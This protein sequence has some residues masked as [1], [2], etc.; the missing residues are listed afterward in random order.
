[1]KRIL[2][3]LACFILMGP[4]A[5][6]SGSKGSGPSLLGGSEV[7]NPD[8]EQGGSEVGNPDP[9][10]GGAEAGNPVEYRVVKGYFNSK[11]DLDTSKVCDYDRVVFVNE[12]L[13]HTLRSVTD[14][15][16][17]E[18]SIAVNQGWAVVPLAPNEQF[19]VS[20]LGE[21]EIYKV[22]GPGESTE[23]KPVPIDLGLIQ[24]NPVTQKADPEYPIEAVDL[25]VGVASPDQDGDGNPDAL[26]NEMLAVYHPGD[27]NNRSR[28]DIEFCPLSHKGVK[29]ELR[30]WKMIASS[31]P[32]GAAGR[33]V[34]VNGIELVIHSM[35]VG[36]MAAVIPMKQEVFKGTIE[37]GFI[38]VNGLSFIGETSYT[39]EC[40]GWTSHEEAVAPNLNLDVTC[41]YTPQGGPDTDGGMCYYWDFLPEAP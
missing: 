14:E 38:R 29:L 6:P 15:C 2:L 3:I 30:K 27:I 1:M 22:I 32:R 34:P 16:R 36:S 12:K 11:E 31:N 7:G 41:Y 13:E 37:A 40:R 28:T 24:K 21:G 20:D 4:G 5:C 35:D 26:F 8:P 19:S 17:F 18:Q 10:G 39:V 25:A 33:L 9:E 23:E